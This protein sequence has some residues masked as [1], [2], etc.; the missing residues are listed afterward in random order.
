MNT[1]TYSDVYVCEDCYFAHHYGYVAGP[2]NNWLVGPD[3]DPDKDATDREP[4]ARLAGLDVSD[5]TNSE[6]GEGI[7]TF[8]WTSCQG[9]GSHLGG[10]RY[11]LAI[12]EQTDN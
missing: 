2:D 3:C 6:T 5:N 11:R 10:S 7:D 4:L 12:F 1:R 9:C 8:S